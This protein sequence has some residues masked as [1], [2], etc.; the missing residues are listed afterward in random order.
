MPDHS[1]GRHTGMLRIGNLRA[2][3]WCMAPVLGSTRQLVAA[4]DGAA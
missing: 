1:N 2:S 4:I 3:R